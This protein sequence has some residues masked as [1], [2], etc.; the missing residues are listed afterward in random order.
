MSARGRESKQNPNKA[1]LTAIAV[2]HLSI[3]AL[4]WRDLRRRGAKKVRGSKA[5]WRVFSGVNTTGSAAYWLL[6]RK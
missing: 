3:T 4:T 5:F 1:L 6:G 2:A